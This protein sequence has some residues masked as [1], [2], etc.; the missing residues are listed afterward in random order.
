MGRRQ[1]LPRLVGIKTPA[2][3]FVFLGYLLLAIGIAP[4]LMQFGL[5]L[6]KNFQD[7]F[8]GTR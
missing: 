8:G 2:P 3:P 7:G 4:S 5:S 1:M 6:F